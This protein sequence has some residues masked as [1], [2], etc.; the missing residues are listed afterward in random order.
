MNAEAARQ[1]EIKREFRSRLFLWATLIILSAALLLHANQS[2]AA[3]KPVSP[4]AKSEQPT[5]FR[6]IP[7]GCSN[8]KPREVIRLRMFKMDKDGNL[9]AVGVVLIPKGC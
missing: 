5:T 1:D 2:V 7:K 4:D 9:V 6:H 8:T 3:V